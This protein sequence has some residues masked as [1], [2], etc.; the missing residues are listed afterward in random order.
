MLVALKIDTQRPKG[1]VCQI[2]SMQFFGTTNKKSSHLFYLFVEITLVM[3]VSQALMNLLMDV[4][5]KETPFHI[6]LVGRSVLERT[7]FM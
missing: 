1:H 5:I 6:Q 4:E 7:V 3:E 2:K